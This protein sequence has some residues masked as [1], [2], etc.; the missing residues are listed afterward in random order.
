MASPVEQVAAEHQRQLIPAHLLFIF[1]DT[2]N[3][4][5]L[6]MT[7]DAMIGI[8]TRTFAGW[9]LEYREAF[10]IEVFY[11]KAGELHRGKR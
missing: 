11:D 3:E 4:G 6:S 9:E 5:L 7:K 8:K 1:E 10:G 2:T